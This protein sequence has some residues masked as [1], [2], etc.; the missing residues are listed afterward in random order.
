MIG[1]T[2]ARFTLRLGPERLG[3]FCHADLGVFYGQVTV[4]V[5]PHD[6]AVLKIQL[7]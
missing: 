6:T 1:R 2:K 5:A 7:K 4:Q 3:D